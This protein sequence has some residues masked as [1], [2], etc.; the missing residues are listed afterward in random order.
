MKKL[1]LP[2]VMLTACFDPIAP[3]VPAGETLCLTDKSCADMGD[4]MLG[5]YGA[6]ENN[7]CV[8]RQGTPPEPPEG[9]EPTRFALGV[10]QRHACAIVDG[11]KVLCWGDGTEGALGQG[12]REW[13]GPF[14]VVGITNAVQISAGR[15]HTC[16]RLDNG[17]I[18]CWGDNASGELGPGVEEAEVDLPI[19]RTLMGKSGPVKAVFVSA[20]IDITCALTEENEIQCWGRWAEEGEIARFWGAEDDP[21]LASL[22]VGDDFMCVREQWGSVL[23]RGKNSVGQLGSGETSDDFQTAFTS[24]SGLPNVIDLVVAWNHACAMTE[25]G[26]VYCWGSNSSGQVTGSTVAGTSVAEATKAREDAEGIGAGDNR[27]CRVKNGGVPECWGGRF[28]FFNAVDT[29]PLGSSALSIDGGGHSAC[30]TTA[31][32]VRCWGRNFYGQLDGTVGQQPPSAATALSSPLTDLQVAYDV[33][34][35]LPANG[36]VE[37]IGEGRLTSP[38]LTQVETATPVVFNYTS[39]ISGLTLWFDH[40]CA[41][42]GPSSEARCWGLNGTGELGTGSEANQP[43]P[44]ALDTTSSIYNLATYSTNTCGLGDGGASVFC[45]GYN[46]NGYFVP[47]WESTT[48]S[49]GRIEGLP[50]GNPS[51]VAVAVGKACAI[52]DG[53]VWCW[54]ANVAPPE[55]VALV[56]DAAAE[57]IGMGDGFAC[58]RTTGGEV[59]C[60]GD[61]DNGVLGEGTESGGELGAQQVLKADT[62]TP[63]TGVTHI[64]VSSSRSCALSEGQV[65]CWGK[66]EG[67]NPAGMQSTRNVRYATP[68]DLPGDAGHVSVTSTHACALVDAVPYCWG[69]NHF[70]QLGLGYATDRGPVLV[71]GTAP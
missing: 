55:E 25:G 20:G 41:L 19:T 39:P 64:A 67:F 66:S 12:N 3:D 70:G 47:D 34:V 33:T 6:C 29:T 38:E 31:T 71:P 32:G 30:A 45:W 40:A 28:G 57:E 65:F 5:E 35:A 53:E 63:L 22:E 42:F 69:D 2:M 13:G 49:P 1:L 26:D 46:F 7:I 17:D 27:S 61:G 54:G 56:N 14:E 16:A 11:G 18:S 44:T 43:T 10:G 68:V 4:P 15:D 36:T 8:I 62:A 48:F 50:A 24:V 59:H 58:A 21:Q 23:C 9:K 60:W 37:V 51:D 52:V